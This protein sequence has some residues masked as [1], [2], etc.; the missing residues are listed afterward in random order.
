M[1]GVY[2]SES[3]FGKRSKIE[4]IKEKRETTIQLLFFLIIFLNMS[5]HVTK[6]QYVLLWL[7]TISC[8][9]SK[10]SVVSVQYS[11]AL[12]RRFLVC[13]KII[14][15]NLHIWLVSPIPSETSQPLAASRFGLAQATNWNLKPLL[16]IINMKCFKVEHEVE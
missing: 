15:V 9:R 14:R 7:H 11:H 3:H 1:K 13:N 2:Q 10:S 4:R 5:H 16:A 12:F 6:R 8:G